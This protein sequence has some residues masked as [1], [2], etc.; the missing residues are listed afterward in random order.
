MSIIPDS[1]KAAMAADFDA[2]ASTWLR[3]LVVYAEAQTLVVS[4]DPNWN[5]LEAWNQNSAS[6]KVT[7]VYT[8]VSG[9]ILWSNEQDWKYTQPYSSRTAGNEAQLK[10][11]D[12]TDQACRLK[13]DA[14]G[15]ALLVNAKQVNIDGRQLV[16]E[17]QPRPHGLFW[18]TYWTFFFVPAM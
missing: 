13:V 4:S 15:Y 7:P 8:T 2:A 9:R 12:Q 18:P 6:F 5:P 3:P 11:K 16:P 14:S 17:S 10:V 1:E